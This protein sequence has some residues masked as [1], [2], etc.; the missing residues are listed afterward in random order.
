MAHISRL[1]GG[2]CERGR[3]VDQKEV[4]VR[5]FILAL[6]YSKTWLGLSSEVTTPER[7]PSPQADSAFRF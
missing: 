2:S 4:P 5:L 7:Q 6:P 3:L 1:P